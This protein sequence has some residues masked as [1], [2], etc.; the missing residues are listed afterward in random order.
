MASG[1]PT[2]NFGL[3]CVPQVFW[4]AL[5]SSYR[6][7]R[8]P[9]QSPLLTHGSSPP[10]RDHSSFLETLQGA[11]LTPRRRATTFHGFR[12]QMPSQEGGF[13]IEGRDILG[14]L[15]L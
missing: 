11:G 1:L 6:H 3:E 10:E 15:S 14:L 5:S 4:A 7:T 13:L 2:D 12:A 8:L 9:T